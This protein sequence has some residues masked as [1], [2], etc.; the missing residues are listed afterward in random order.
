L[1]YINITHIKK[2]IKITRILL[3][4]YY[5]LEHSNKWIKLA[6]NNDSEYGDLKLIIQLKWVLRYRISVFSGFIELE[7]FEWTSI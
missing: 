5:F 7:L 6:N 3:T 1:A 4:I 2:S